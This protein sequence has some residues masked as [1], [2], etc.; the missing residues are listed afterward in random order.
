VQKFLNG[1]KTPAKKLDLPN[2]LDIGA[3]NSL[4]IQ[5]AGRL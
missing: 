5:C 2:S 4:G 3:N 1:Q